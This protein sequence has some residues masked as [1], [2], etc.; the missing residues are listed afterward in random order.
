MIK[1][2]LAFRHY[3][4]TDSIPLHYIKQI[5][6]MHH[7]VSAV[8]DVVVGE[9]WPEASIESVK[10]QI[11]Q[12]GLTFEVVESVPVHEDIKRGYPSRDNYIENY[13]TT[14]RRLGKAGI[15]VVC[16]NFMPVFD[17]TR[18]DL[19][20]VMDDGSTTLSYDKATADKMDP[21]KGDLSLPGWDVSY[22]KEQ[23]QD[24]ITSYQSINE[25]TLFEHLSYFLKAVIPVAEEAGIKMA[26]HPDDPPYPIFSLPRIVTSKENL[27]RLLKIIDSPAHGLTV[28]TGSL[29]SVYSN[30]IYAIL[31]EFAALKKI[32]FMHVRNIKLHEDGMSFDETAHHSSKGSLDMVKILNILVKHDFDGYLR[33][34]HGR[35]IFGEAGKP[36]YGLYDRALGASYL[37]GIYET[38]IKMKEKTQ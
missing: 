32:F 19:A 14:L 35:M 27:H 23:L 31:E 20:K 26:I 12:A 6:T 15:K 8:Y 29:G 22:A 25:E 2:K 28:C 34:D 38:L 33:P 21:I 37:S 30:D 17:W 10:K 3:G 4:K 5:P 13:K 24:L 16:Y 11:E 9:A 18:T 1:M 7:I 36:G